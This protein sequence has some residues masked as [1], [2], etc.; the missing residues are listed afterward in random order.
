MAK[1]KRVGSWGDIPQET[2]D[3]FE[4][5]VEKLHDEMIPLDCD[6]DSPISYLIVNRMTHEPIGYLG[7]PRAEVYS[8]VKHGYLKV[9]PDRLQEMQDETERTL[10]D[11]VSMAASALERYMKLKL[12]HNLDGREAKLPIEERIRHACRHCAKGVGFK[13]DTSSSPLRD[14][15]PDYPLIYH[16]GEDFGCDALKIRREQFYAAHPELGHNPEPRWC[17]N[18]ECRCL[19]P[20]DDSRKGKKDKNVCI[21]PRCGM[22]NSKHYPETQKEKQ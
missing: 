10:A 18:P 12:M 3:A 15:Y 8:Y 20:W 14:K 22:D 9:H 6:G 17:M 16:V 7:V 11:N 5:A 21:N 19:L 4:K 13:P 2:F 1:A